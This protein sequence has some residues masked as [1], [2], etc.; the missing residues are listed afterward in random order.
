MS[1]VARLI[2][3]LRRETELVRELSGILQQ[4]HKCIVAQDVEALE[5]SNRTKEE[6]VL[7]F[8]SLEHERREVAARLA[9]QIG[10]PA[11]DVRV[12][13]LAPALDPADGRALEESAETLRAAVGALA[14]LIAVSRGFLEQS[15]LGVRGLLSLIQSLRSPQPGTY[16]A[17]GRPAQGDP[18][19]L[20][21]RR[22]V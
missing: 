20:A 16:D 3:Y 11:D 10:L 2:D 1:D 5:R 22:E 6:R 18:S 4:D 19:G 17:T 15:I 13:T 12:S 14:E 21:L 8:Q 7:A 9:A